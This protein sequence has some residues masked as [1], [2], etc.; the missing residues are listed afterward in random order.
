MSIATTVCSSAPASA[1]APA[2]RPARRTA[3]AIALYRPRWLRALHALRRAWTAWRAAARRRA[4]LRALAELDDWLLRDVGLAD[5][6]PPKSGAGVMSSLDLE[7][8]R[9]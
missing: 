2:L 1:L 7:R 6:V 4:D 9:W 5:Q 8:S 3:T